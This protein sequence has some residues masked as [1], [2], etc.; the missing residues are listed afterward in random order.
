MRDLRYANLRDANLTGADLRYANLSE[1]D[2]TGANLDFAAWPLWCGSKGVRVDARIAAQLAAHFCA[3]D[4]EDEG[5]QAARAAILPFARTS[6]RAEELLGAVAEE[7]E[8]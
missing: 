5:Y 6:H 4:C 1:A 3:F 2:L 7:G 8:G